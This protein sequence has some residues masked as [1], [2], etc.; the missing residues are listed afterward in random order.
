ME[1]LKWDEKYS[2][3]VKECDAQ[4]K[5]LFNIINLLIANN[6]K[7]L[8]PKEIFI[9]LSE[10]VEYSRSH[11]NTE[12]NYMIDANYPDFLAHNEAHQQYTKKMSL[13]LEAF[14]NRRASLSEDILIFLKSWWTE[15]ILRLDKQYGVFLNKKGIT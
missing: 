11:F 4:H 9:I 1:I 10:L 6:E 15:H 13:F 8:K 14:E 5:K 2:V 12:V 7:K 3:N